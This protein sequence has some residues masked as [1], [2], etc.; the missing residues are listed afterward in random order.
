MKRALP[1]RLEAASVLNLK[2][3]TL[4]NYWTIKYADMR[5]HQE[6]NTHY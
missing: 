2:K 5:Y 6:L 4:A 1:S 3:C